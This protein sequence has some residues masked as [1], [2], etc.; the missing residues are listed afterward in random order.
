MGIQRYKKKKKK[1]QKKKKK[2]KKKRKTIEQTVFSQVSLHRVDEDQYFL[3]MHQTP[4]SERKAIFF[5]SMNFIHNEALDD[6]LN[7]RH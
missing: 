7:E 6:S 5:I 1:N 2:K 4:Y 3:Q